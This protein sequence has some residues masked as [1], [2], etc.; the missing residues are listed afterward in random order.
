[1]QQKL[2]VVE[3]MEPVKTELPESFIY[4]SAKKQ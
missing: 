2:L 3:K 1:M 4:Y